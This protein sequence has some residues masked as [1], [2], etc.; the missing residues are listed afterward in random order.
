MTLFGIFRVLEFRGKLSF[1][2]ITDAGT[3]PDSFLP[4]WE[5]FLEGVFLPNLRGLVG[6]L[7]KLQSP[8]LFPILK[9]G[10]SPNIRDID[11][12]SVSSSL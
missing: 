3:M 7:P 11:L 8:V 2:S 12:P 5:Q 1:S 4:Q 10:P 9:S 6:D